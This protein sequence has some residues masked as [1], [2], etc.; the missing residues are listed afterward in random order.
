MFVT[1]PEGFDATSRLMCNQSFKV[2]KNSSQV[3]K[4]FF[5]AGPSGGRRTFVIYCHRPSMSM[6]RRRKHKVKFNCEN[7]FFSFSKLKFTTKIET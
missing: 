6:G 2:L 1:H 5:R 4:M 7:F 3:T